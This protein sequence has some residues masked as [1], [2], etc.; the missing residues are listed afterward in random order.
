MFAEWS[1]LSFALLSKFPEYELFQVLRFLSVS[2]IY[3]IIEHK[4]LLY[5]NDF[6]RMNYFK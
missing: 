6:V 2:C 5:E 3:S 4:L 1:R